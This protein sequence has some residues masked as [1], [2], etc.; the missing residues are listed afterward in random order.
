MK[1]F[2]VVHNKIMKEISLHINSLPPGPVL[3]GTDALWHDKM[4]TLNVFWMIKLYWKFALV[5]CWGLL[6]IS[7]ISNT[8]LPDELEDDLSL[9]SVFWSIILYEN[10]R[11]CFLT[12]VWYGKVALVYRQWNKVTVTLRV[13]LVWAVMIM[14]MCPESTCYWVLVLRRDRS[15]YKDKNVIITDLCHMTQG[16]VVLV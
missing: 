14:L 15:G 1:S 3:N 7:I 2:Q 10:Y 5:C 8:I 11:V 6:K 12:Q 13:W 16:P 9:S 4:H